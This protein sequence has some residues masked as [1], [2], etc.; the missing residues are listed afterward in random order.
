MIDSKNRYTLHVRGVTVM[1]Y[2]RNTQDQI[3]EGGST[4]IAYPRPII[5]LISILSERY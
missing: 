4:G 1:G 3:S 2:R 5:K